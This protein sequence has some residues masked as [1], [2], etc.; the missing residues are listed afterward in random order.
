LALGVFSIGL[1]TGSA[2]ATTL[3]FQDTM[4]YF[5][6]YSNGTGDDLR[7]EIGNPNVE[8]MTITFDE[9]SDNLL[10]SVV[11][12]MTNRRHFD[13]LFINNDSAGQ[14]WDFMIRDT[15]SRND[16]LGKDGGF[17]SVAENYT[18]T[19]VTKTSY[20]EGHPF[21]IEMNDLTL[22][23][24]TLPVIWDVD[25]STLTYNFSNY[26][27]YLADTFNFGY[28]PDCANDVM[29]TTV[30]EPASMLLFGAGLAGLAGIVTR[31]RKN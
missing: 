21:G 5:P 8:S 22:I 6:G 16:S 2:M 18:Y 27:I 3:T 9:E 31:R 12:N 15:K 17:Y 29:M 26:A 1:L 10:Q 25:A 23:N 24:T 4:N 19:I 7:D 11:V 28:A 30:P 20:R 14:G 13:T